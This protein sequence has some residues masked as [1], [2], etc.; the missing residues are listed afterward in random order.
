[1][2]RIGPDSYLGWDDEQVMVVDA[3][4]GLIQL[5]SDQQ[6]E[7]ILKTELGV[8]Q[9]DR[10]N[11]SWF[12]LNELG[13]AE[14][15]RRRSSGSIESRVIEQ[16]DIASIQALNDGVVIADEESNISFYSSHSLVWRWPN[17]REHGQL[18]TSMNAHRD[19]LCLAIEGKAITMDEPSREIEI[20]ENKNGEFHHI[21][22]SAVPE[23]I[24][25][26]VNHAGEWYFGGRNGGVYRLISGVLKCIWQSKHAIQALCSSPRGLVVGSWFHIRLLDETGQVK[27]TVE[28]PGMPTM[29]DSAQ[30][31]LLFAGE[32]QN[33][34]TENEAVGLLNMG[35]EIVEIDESE[36]TLWFDKELSISSSQQIDAAELYS[37]TDDFLHLLG[38]DERVAASE[39]TGFVTPSFDESSTHSLL[40]AL[41]ADITQPDSQLGD[42]GNGLKGD[43]DLI[44]MLS[45]EVLRK[46]PP[47]ANA[48]GDQT[49]YVDESNTAIIELDANN[50]ADPQ[51]RITATEW[52]DGSGKLLASTKRLNLKL[53]P[54]NYSFELRVQDDDGQWTMDLVNVHVL[55]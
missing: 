12:I 21:S 51:Q 33:D 10:S 13:Q 37:E 39:S 40:G 8:I 24:M 36:L 17:L 30:D 52:R 6:M 42:D 53:K 55:E 11:Y 48:G 43:A 7:V 19:Q 49:V 14:A 45:G 29:I 28:T 3:G 44:E 47:Q 41:Q 32:D 34:W 38:D 50:S 27:W 22:H 15:W 25:H 46:V 1:M 26:S 23:P 2:E 35:D 20:W 31:S 54:G 18:L 16:E 5:L 9:V 4:V